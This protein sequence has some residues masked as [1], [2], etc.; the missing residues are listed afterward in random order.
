MSFASQCFNTPE[1]RHEN[2][3]RLMALPLEDKIIYSKARIM[4]FY[5]K[6]RGKVYV[7]FSGGKDSTVLLHLIRSMYPDIPAV[8]YDTGMEFPEIREFA[9]AQSNVTALHPDMSFKKVIE[10]YGYPCIGKEAAHCIDLAQRDKPS[11]LRQMASDSRYG[12]A[13]FAYMVD[14]PFKVSEK[15]C[16]VMKKKPAKEYHKETGRCPYIGTRVDESSLRETKWISKGDN[17]EGDIPSSNPLSIWTDRDVDEYIRTRGVE[18]CRIYDMG[19]E[20]TGC[21]FCMFGIMSDR[22]RFV[23]LKATHPKQWAYCMRP[24]E[25]GGLGMHEVCDF[26]GIPTGCEQMTLE[27]FS[28]GSE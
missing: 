7:A 8:F 23:K 1:E 28:E 26:M 24:R 16:N 13:K 20:R 6:C 19:Y 22:N 25:E 9:L 21:I 12:F 15:C 11:G 4:E 10:T 14:A 2:L 27:D 18:Y 5:V 17:R 3:T